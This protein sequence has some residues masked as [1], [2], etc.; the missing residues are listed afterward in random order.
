[1]SAGTDTA[2]ARSALT[3]ATGPAIPAASVAALTLY[4]MIKAVDRAAVIGEIAVLEKSGGRSGAWS[5]S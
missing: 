4:D 2:T 5:R 3:V 1:M